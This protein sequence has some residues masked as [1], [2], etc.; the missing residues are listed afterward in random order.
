[1]DARIA[2][3]TEALREAGASAPMLDTDSL[4]KVVLDALDREH[5]TASVDVPAP[6]PANPT[7]PVEV[8]A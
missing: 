2:T 4:A 5:G 6:E 1:M 3:V 7:T 8:P